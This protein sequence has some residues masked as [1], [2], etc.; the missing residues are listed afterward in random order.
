M[1][2]IKSVRRLP[3][4]G[5]A[6]VPAGQQTVDRVSA[7]SSSTLTQRQGWRWRRTGEVRPVMAPLLPLTQNRRDALNRCDALNHCGF[8][9]KLW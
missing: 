7:A 9:F 2:A 6:G 5:S 3:V 8:L 4:P 1:G